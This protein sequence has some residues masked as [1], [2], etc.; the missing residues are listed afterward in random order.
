[1]KIIEK[2]GLIIVVLFVFFMFY[3]P[4]FCFLIVGSLALCHGIESLTFLNYIKKNGIESLGEILSYE[5]DEDG[6]KTPIIEFKTLKGELIK[7]KP[8][9]YASTDLSIF[10]T[11]KNNIN[12]KITVIYSEENPEKFVIKTEKDFNIGTIIL[13]IIVGLIF[14][15]LSI[16]NLL[17]FLNM[18]I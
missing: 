18:G 7:Q 10:R 9:Y 11:Y 17:G 13:M 12:K 4:I 2:Y 3:K 1:M 16:G 14:L 6:Y 15:V 5:S 8:Y